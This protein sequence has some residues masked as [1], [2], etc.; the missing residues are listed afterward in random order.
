MCIRDRADL[1]AVPEG[2]LTDIL[3]YHVVDGAVF[4]DTVVT[5]ESATTLDGRDIQIMV[6]DSGVV[7]NEFVNVIIT[8][9]K[10]SNGVIHVIDTVLSPPH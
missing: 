9:I 8:D 1:L 4:A 3:K 2:F 6:T 7:L 5:L 10:A